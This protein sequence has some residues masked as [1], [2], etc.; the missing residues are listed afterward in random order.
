MSFLNTLHTYGTLHSKH[1]SFKADPIAT[2]R[3]SFQKHALKQ[4]NA[5]TEASSL[6][7]QGW[8]S[9][10][11][12]ETVSVSLR[13]GTTTMKLEDDSTHVTVSSSAVA[14]DFYNA[15]IEACTAGEFDALFLATRRSSKSSL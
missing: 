9:V 11:P 7:R 2:M 12:D 10:L 14:I 13:N 8:Y 1:P 15:A 5:L 4:I 3:K 6:G